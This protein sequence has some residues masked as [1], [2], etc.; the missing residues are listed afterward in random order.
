MKS[1]INSFFFPPDSCR[2]KKK[3]YLQNFVNITITLRLHWSS[4]PT[5][6]TATQNPGTDITDHSLQCNS[7]EAEQH[8]LGENEV[9]GGEED[10][11]AQTT[12]GQSS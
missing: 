7:G 12:Y 9:R 5:T 10:A 4:D 3:L 8:S 1:D 2:P 11:I 6:T